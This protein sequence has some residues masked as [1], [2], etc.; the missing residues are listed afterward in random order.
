MPSNGRLWRHIH[1]KRIRHTDLTDMF[2]GDHS[3]TGAGYE[4]CGHMGLKNAASTCAKI[5]NRR[6]WG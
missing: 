6:P 2:D 1:D 4:Q 3:N 5:Y